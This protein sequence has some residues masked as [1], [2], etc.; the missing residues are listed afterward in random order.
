MPQL[1]PKEASWKMLKNKVY[2]NGWEAKNKD[3]LI[4]RIR[5][6]IF[7]NG[8]KCLPKATFSGEN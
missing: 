8:S 3:E 6:K 7:K 4:K 5:Q 2:E 1:R